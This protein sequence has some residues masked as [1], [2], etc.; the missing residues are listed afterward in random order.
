MSAVA[1]S[2]TAVSE[3]SGLLLT[4]NG[5]GAGVPTASIAAAPIAAVAAAPTASVAAA[6]TASVAAFPTAS[7]IA[8]DR[9]LLDCR[10]KP[11]RIDIKVKLH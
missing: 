3:N 1:E 9:Q 7:V 10:I 11:L 8:D 2:S 4:L 6:P 5:S